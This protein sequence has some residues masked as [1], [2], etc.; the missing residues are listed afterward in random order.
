MRRFSPVVW[1]VVTIV[2][3]PAAAQAQHR[4]EFSYM[5][6]SGDGFAGVEVDGSWYQTE[7]DVERSVDWDGSGEHALPSSELHLRTAA[8]HSD[9]EDP[10]S[11]PE[12]AAWLLLATGLIA[13]AGA[14]VLRRAVPAS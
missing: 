10:V 14:T 1:A 4:C 2:M 7:Y 11:V 8:E 13:M 9:V 5:H 3:V 6:A 12:P